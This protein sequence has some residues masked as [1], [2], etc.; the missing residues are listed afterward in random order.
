[1]PLS[2]AG[3]ANNERARV[4][5]WESWDCPATLPQLSNGFLLGLGSPGSSRGEQQSPPHRV[6]PDGQSQP[7]EV[8][9]SDGVQHCPLQW[10]L[11]PGQNPTQVG[12]PN[13]GR[14]QYSLEPQQL[15]SQTSPLQM[16]SP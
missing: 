14:S 5:G 4:V 9:T 12:S 11:R 2:C 6:F 16:Q 15:F 10:R 13:R 7:V 1:V 3:R 8:H